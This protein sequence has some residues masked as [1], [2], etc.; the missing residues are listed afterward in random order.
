MRQAGLRGVHGQR[1]RVRT[2]VPDR[3]AP[4]APERGE[5][6]FAPAPIGAPDRLWLADSSDVATVEGWRSLAVVLDGFS[7]QVV[8][9]ALAAHLRT[10]LVVD[11]LTM[12]LQARRPAAG[13]IHHSDHGGHYTAIAFGQ[14]L[15]AA[16]LLA[17]MGSVGDADDHAVAAAFFS[18][19]KTE[20]TE[21]QVWPTRAAARLAIF[22]YLAGW[23]NRRRRHSTLGYLA[24]V[25]FA[26]LASRSTAT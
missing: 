24:P 10:A 23:Y 13:R 20:L 8:G 17:S 18:S 14:R 26:A 19:L 2:T 11:A 7:R 22:A 25:D 5:R 4:R 16:G 3:A 6:A 12:A 21:R 9:W 15:C 1:R